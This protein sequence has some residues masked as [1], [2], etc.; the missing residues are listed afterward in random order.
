MRVELNIKEIGKSRMISQKF[1][2]GKL[3]MS[4]L[5]LKPEIFS[6]KMSEVSQKL[7]NAYVAK[8]MEKVKNEEGKG[9][10]VKD[11]PTTNLDNTSVPTRKNIIDV[12]SNINK[13]KQA[14]MENDKI[15]AETRARKRMLD[16]IKMGRHLQQ[17]PQHQQVVKSDPREY[18][19][20]PEPGK[21]VLT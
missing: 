5:M 7:Q 9:D 6:R 16:N 4:T 8:K 12:M 21:L 1:L 19:M 17:Y 11:E 3:P 15:E 14:K 13:K 2:V 10:V 18:P 20:N